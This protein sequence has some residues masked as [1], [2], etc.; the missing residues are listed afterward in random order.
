MAC[1]CEGNGE[2]LAPCR[3][4]QLLDQDNTQKKVEYCKLCKVYLC[5]TC[6]KNPVRRILAFGKQ[7]FE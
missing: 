3:C 2:T 7:F 1:G 6:R 5:A 4:C